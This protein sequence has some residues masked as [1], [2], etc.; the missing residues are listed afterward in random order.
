VSVS[1]RKALLEAGIACLNDK[2]YANTTARD[3]AGRANVSLGAIGYH[4]GSTEDLMDKAMAEAVRRWLEP[5][6]TIISAVPDSAAR[7]EL[8]A[9]IDYLLET[10]ETH[11]ELVVAYFEA[12]VRAQRSPDLRNA[13]AAA[14]DALRVALASGIRQLQAKDAPARQVDPEMSATLL[15]ATFDGLLIQ[16]LLDPDRVPSGETIAETL[17]RAARLVIPASRHK[18]AAN[19]GS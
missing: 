5:L 6:I 7:Q 9:G 16:W 10:F 8:G 2:G 3:I 14:F 11:R 18:R 19:V 17:L 12:L 15:M 1:N 13:M 4:F